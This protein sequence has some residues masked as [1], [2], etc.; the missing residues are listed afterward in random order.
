L[1][2]CS[3]LFWWMCRSLERNINASG[4]NGGQEMAI[5]ATTKYSGMAHQR[6]GIV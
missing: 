5:T 4:V 2:L 1:A 3:F 6:A